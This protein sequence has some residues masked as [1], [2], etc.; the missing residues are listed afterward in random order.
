MH[1]QAVQGKQPH[2]WVACVKQVWMVGE[3]SAAVG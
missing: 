3:G 2:T 1:G